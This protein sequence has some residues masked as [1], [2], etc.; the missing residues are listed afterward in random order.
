MEGKKED[1]NKEK[2]FSELVMSSST[3]FLVRLI[4]T[5]SI[6]YKAEKSKEN[7]EAFYFYAAILLRKLV[8]IKRYGEHPTKQQM[9]KFEAELEGVSNLFNLFNFDKN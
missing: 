5:A 6:V 3:E 4:N 2:L 7:L 9:Q 1:G 8:L